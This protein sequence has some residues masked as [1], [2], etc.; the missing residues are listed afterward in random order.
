MKHAVRIVLLVMLLA[1]LP[2]RGYAG[3]L[4]ALC[5]SNHGGA[6]V[7]EDHAY[8]H[9]DSRHHNADD[10]AANP[11][12]VASVCSIC[13]SCCAGA[14]LAPAAC[15]GVAFQSPVSDRIPFFGAQASGFVPGHLDRPPLSL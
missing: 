6:A 11:S 4:S 7:A 1:T 14:V 3:V 9:G 10:G 15:I 12:H 5:E 2:M 13:A 8:E